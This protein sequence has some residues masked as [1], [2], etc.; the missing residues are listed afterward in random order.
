M[1]L[2]SFPLALQLPAMPQHT[3]AIFLSASL[4]IG[5]IGT[6]AYA[7]NQ[8]PQPLTP[9]AAAIGGT[10]NNNELI[11]PSGGVIAPTIVNPSTPQSSGQSSGSSS[12]GQ[13]TGSNG[14]TV[15]FPSN[16]WIFV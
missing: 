7:Q 16:D 13:Q 5:T 3:L 4:L 2:P 12:G 15:H 14:R 10:T 11:G 9:G 6:G 1:A 8:L